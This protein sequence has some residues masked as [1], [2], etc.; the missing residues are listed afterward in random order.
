[1]AQTYTVNTDTILYAKWVR[2]QFAIGDTG[3]A[4]GIVFFDMD[5]WRYMEAAPQDIPCKFQ[6][7]VYGQNVGT[8]TALGSGK[9]NTEILGKF[10]EYFILVFF[11][12]QT[13][14]YVR[15]GRTK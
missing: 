13:R 15:F 11:R 1:M 5:G 2:V 10:P 9:Q 4:G 14:L 7:G 8:Q 3:P 6:W 12:R